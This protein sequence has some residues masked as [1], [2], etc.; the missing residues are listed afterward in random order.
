[1]GFYQHYGFI[2]VGSSQRLHQ[3]ISRINGSLQRSPG[4]WPLLL[5][6]GTGAS[7]LSNVC[8]SVGD[9]T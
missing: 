9:P 3:K 8:A 5:T 6:D 4:R 2:R 1:M 7:H